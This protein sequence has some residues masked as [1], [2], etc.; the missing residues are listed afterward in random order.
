MHQLT[1]SIGKA[2]LYAGATLLPAATFAA[3]IVPSCNNGPCGYTDLIT[4]ANNIISFLVLDISVPI[5][6]IAFVYAGFLYIT[7]GGNEGQISKAHEIFKK[8]LIGFIIAAS[9]WLLVHMI[10]TT[11]NVGSQY[12][13]VVQ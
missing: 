9:A 10:L 8:V 1:K 5:A 13:T 11:L 2:A 6:T 4:M 3:G 12:K 7:S